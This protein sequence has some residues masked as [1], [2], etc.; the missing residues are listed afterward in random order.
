MEDPK[1]DK[2]LLGTVASHSKRIYIDR[3]NVAYERYL[4]PG[5]MIARAYIEA[6]LAELHRRGYEVVKKP[7]K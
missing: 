2:A 6:F 7:V 1:L 5:E 3:G 4:E